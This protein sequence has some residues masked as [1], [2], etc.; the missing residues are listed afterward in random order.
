MILVYKKKPKLYKSLGF[1][2]LHH[3]YLRFRAHTH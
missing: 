3:L 2:D 1:E